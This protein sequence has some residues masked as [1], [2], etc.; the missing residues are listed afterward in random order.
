[1]SVYK[2]EKVWYYRFTIRGQRYGKAIPEAR[3]KWQ[4]EQ[5]EASAKD[6]VFRGRYGDEPSNI[7]LKEFIERVFLPWAKDNKRS[8]KNDV[9][10]AKP[11]VAYFKNKMMREITRFN[12]EQFKKER[13][14]S[15][16]GRGINRAPASVDRELQLLSRIFSLAI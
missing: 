6:A 11:I 1:M 14:G 5:A 2:R 7:T 4:A 8:W 3:T 10:R 16:N 15:F 9:S 12:V 13:R